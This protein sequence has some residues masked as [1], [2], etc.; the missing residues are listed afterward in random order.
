M[1]ITIFRL[2]VL[3]GMLAIVLSTLVRLPCLGVFLASCLP[4]ACV[5]SWLRTERQLTKWLAYPAALTPVYLTSFGPM[6]FLL[7]VVYP[8]FRTTPRWVFS[9][10]EMV[11][12]LHY[13]LAHETSLYWVVVDYAKQW[14][15]LA[16]RG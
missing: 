8:D 12:P 7:T 5:V 4:I 6:A 13:Y 9:L 15:R 3:T 10:L 16:G 1:R 14:E 2:L 11:Y